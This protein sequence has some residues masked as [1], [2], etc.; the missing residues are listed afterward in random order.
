MRY[1]GI[2]EDVISRLCQHDEGAEWSGSATHLDKHSR[3]AKK[4]FP[5]QR[6]FVVLDIGSRIYVESR[7]SFIF[8][9]STC[10]SNSEHLRKP[11]VAVDKHVNICS[12]WVAKSKR[13]RRR[14][15]RWQLANRQRK[16]T[17]DSWENEPIA[18]KQLNKLVAWKT[19]QAR[20]SMEDMD[21]DALLYIDPFAIAYKKKSA[22]IFD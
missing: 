22:C 1:T 3:L 20:R 12:D 17:W 6:F 9:T 14:G 19:E 16:C 21:K 7:E 10:V 2:T 11:L 13:K 5:W 15:K 4:V 8:T 18:V